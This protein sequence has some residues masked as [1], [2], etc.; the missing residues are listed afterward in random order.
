MTA[1]DEALFSAAHGFYNFAITDATRNRSLVY[2][3]LLQPAIALPEHYFLQGSWLTKHFDRAPSRDSWVEVGLRNGFVVPYLRREGSRFAELLST[4]QASDRR[5]FGTH[6]N[7][8]A[9]RLDRTPFTPRQWSSPTNSEVF[10]TV[11]SEYMRV[12][13]PPML[14]AQADPDDFRGFWSRSRD[15]IDAEL[16]EA[17][18]RSYDKLGSDGMLLSQLIQVSGERLLGQD[19]GRIDS[20][21]DLLGRARRQ[22]GAGAERDLRAYYTCVCELYNRTLAD[23]LNSAPNSPRWEH[24]VAAMDLWRDDVLDE[25]PAASEEGLPLPDFDIEIRLPRVE[26]LANLSGD[27]LLAVRR[28]APCERYLES[29]ALWKAAPHDQVL[30][31]ELV[32]ALQRY[33]EE[34]RKLVGK[35]V[36]V[37]G[38]KPQFVSKVSD[39][40]RALERVPGMVQGFLAVGATAATM[41]QALPQVV[42]MG[43][44]GLFALQS[45]AKYYSPTKQIEVELSASTGVHIH[46]DVTISRA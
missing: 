6:A 11:L 10:G 35:D 8:V 23:S 36:A 44:F 43:L 7:S 1:P 15:W 46:A 41:A 19:C 29:L 27:V 37:F 14:H 31:D 9:E 24:F 12:D 39:I 16:H 32:S 3:L 25:D 2:N 21:D 18:E 42:P 34:M 22:L 5:G 40:S 38:M 45:A 33:A 4:M 30:R 26:H 20:I 17:G 28:S 13:K